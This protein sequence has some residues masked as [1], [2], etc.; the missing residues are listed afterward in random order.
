MKTISK[1]VSL[2]STGTVGVLAVVVACS[3]PSLAVTA[4]PSTTERTPDKRTTTVE[5]GNTTSTSACSRFTTL[6][7]TTNAKLAER[8]SAMKVDFGK[9]LS[10]IDSRHE[11]V[12]QKVTT[13]RTSLSDKFDVRVAELKAKDGITDI[14]LA[15]IDTFVQ[16]MKTAEAAR[17]E[18]VDSARATYRAALAQE[19]ADKQQKL[20]EAAATFQAAVSAAI[21]T[22]KANCGNGEAAATLKAA[23]KSAREAFEASRKAEA[24]RSSIKQLAETRTEAIKAANAEFKKNAESYR[25]TLKAAL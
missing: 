20:S 5:P 3:T 11:A 18:A 14:Q 1:L 15:A 22:A 7:T 6:S 10:N 12:D 17:E 9:R 19:V 8:Q 24:T 13:F 25:A 16:S 23:I 21:T 4:E 2:V